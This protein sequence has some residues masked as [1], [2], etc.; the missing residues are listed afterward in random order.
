MIASIPWLQSVLNF[1][2]IYFYVASN[3]VQYH[4][5]KTHRNKIPK[6]GLLCSYSVLRSFTW[7]KYDIIVLPLWSL[8][9][10]KTPALQHLEL[11]GLPSNSRNYP[12]TDNIPVYSFTGHPNT[13]HCFCRVGVWI[14][15]TIKLYTCSDR[16][17]C[18]GMRFIT[19]PFASHSRLSVRHLRGWR[20]G[21]ITRWRNFLHKV[22]SI[23]ATLTN[24]HSILPSLS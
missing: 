22:G 8:K 17:G 4:E 14:Q 19:H 2:I 18:G 21:S 16:K 7:G 24:V 13:W 3:P 5:H 1:L 10:N 15:T 20:T 23:A 9:H 11:C 12:S 6:W